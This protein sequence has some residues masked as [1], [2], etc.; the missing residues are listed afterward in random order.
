[1]RAWPLVDLPFAVSGTRTG[2]KDGVR[3]DDVQAT[4]GDSDLKGSMRISTTGRPR[5][6]VDVRSDYLDLQ[7]LL[8]LSLIHI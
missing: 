3:M 7:L 2:S 8:D 1:M 5:V 4:L 6:D